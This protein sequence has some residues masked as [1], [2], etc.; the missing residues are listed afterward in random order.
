[1]SLSVIDWIDWFWISIVIDCLRLENSILKAFKVA[2]YNSFTIARVL[3]TKAQV[4]CARLKENTSVFRFLWRQH[5]HK[6]QNWQQIFSCFLRW[7]FF[8]LG[9]V[10]TTHI[11]YIKYLTFVKICQ[12]LSNIFRKWQI[13]EYWKICMNKYLDFSPWCGEVWKKFSEGK[14]RY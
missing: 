11:C 13:T 9:G 6:K 1:M 8:E 5:E 4:I 2:P 14:C 12:I 3:M 7:I 10:V